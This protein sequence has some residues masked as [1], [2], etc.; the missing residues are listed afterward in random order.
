MSPEMEETT[1]ISACQRVDSTAIYANAQAFPT[2]GANC[3]DTVLLRPN[4]DVGLSDER[5]LTM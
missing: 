5:S 3:R 4:K 1:E 2:D